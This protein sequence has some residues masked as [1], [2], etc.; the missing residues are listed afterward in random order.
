MGIGLFMKSA[1]TLRIIELMD[2]KWKFDINSQM[3]DED[4]RKLLS[5]MKYIEEYLQE[6]LQTDIIK[7]TETIEYLKKKEKEHNT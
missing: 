3:S 5:H 7:A 2:G 6:T 1:L 4:I